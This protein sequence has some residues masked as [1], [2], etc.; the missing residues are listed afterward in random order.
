M[1]GSPGFA[2]VGELG[3]DIAKWHWFLLLMFRL[4]VA[5][6]LG[7]KLTLGMG[8]VGVLEHTICSQC[9]YG[10]EGICVSDRSGN[11]VSFGL[12]WGWVG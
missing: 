11:P 9:S 1:L 3:S 6:L 5:D 12:R 8:E 2:V 7:V 10:P 4:A